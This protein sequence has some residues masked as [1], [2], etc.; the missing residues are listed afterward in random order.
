[1]LPLREFRYEPPKPQ[2]RR[3]PF[4]IPALK[5]FSGISVQQPVTFF[6]GDNGSGK[7]TLLESLAVAAGF[8]AEGG[9]R[10]ASYDMVSTN[11]ELARALRLIWNRKTPNGFFFRAESFFSFATYLEDVEKENTQTTPFHAYGGRSLHE[12]SHGESF[13]SLFRYRLGSDRPAL[14]LFD[15][16]E[17]ALSITGQMALLRF[18]WDWERSGRVQAIIATHSPILLAYPGAAI[19]TFDTSPLSSTTYKS[20]DPYQMTRAFLEDPDR[21]LKELFR[22]DSREDS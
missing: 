18:M 21:F 9:S 22:S 10:N 15:E 17:S 19:W 8:H 2:P 12:R 5:G 4:N 6:I 13:L 1:M 16:P 14:F 3:Y 11:T 7:S 20:S